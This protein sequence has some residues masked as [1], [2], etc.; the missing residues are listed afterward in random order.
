MISR[1]SLAAVVLLV[2]S[3]ASV[4][5]A[6]KTVDI[7]NFAFQ[8]KSV[9]TTVGGTIQWHNTTSMT[10]HTSTA[11]KLSVW[12]LTVSPGQTKAQVMHSAGTFAYHCAIH[13]SM[14]ASVKVKMTVTLASHTYTIHVGDA[15]L[16]AGQKHEI[17]WRKGSGAYVA[18]GAPTTATSVSFQPTSAGK[19]QFRTRL[20]NGSTTSDWSPVLTIQA[21]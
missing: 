5:A 17:Q 11:D 7:V 19:Y 10:T 3:A 14:K 8:T 1:A 4:S 13:T 2:L 15:A 12:N 21:T 9:K 20:T 6:T 16:P 18:F